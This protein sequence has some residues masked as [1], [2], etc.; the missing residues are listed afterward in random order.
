M[1]GK[2]TFLKIALRQGCLPVNLLHIFRT[3]FL[4]NTWTAASVS[5][6]LRFIKKGL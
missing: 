1:P 5:L 2:A 6:L 3:L 4:K